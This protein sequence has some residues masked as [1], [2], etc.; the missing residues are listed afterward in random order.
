MWLGSLDYMAKYV[1]YIILHS[2]EQINC[3][4]LK[5]KTVC[6]QR[7]PSQSTHLRLRKLVSVMC[8]RC[9]YVSPFYFVILL[10]SHNDV[11]IN[12]HSNTVG[13]LF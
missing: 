2:L 12:R 5:N 6:V 10:L 9:R 8:L 3:A 4:G 1:Y 11:F 7:N 13:N